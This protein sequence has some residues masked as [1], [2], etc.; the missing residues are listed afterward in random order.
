MRSVPEHGVGSERTLGLFLPGEEAEAS[1]RFL[2]H[3]YALLAKA[4]SVLEK[5]R[6]TFLEH[7]EVDKRQ[8]L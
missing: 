4:E 6:S 1:D 7:R 2:K 3:A 8:R 5:P